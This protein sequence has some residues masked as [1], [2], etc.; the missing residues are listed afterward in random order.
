MTTRYSLF[1]NIL[2]VSLPDEDT[3]S[4]PRILNLLGAGEKLDFAG[5]QAYQQYAW[6]AFLVQVASL[7]AY[8]SG[9]SDLAVAESVW[10]SALLELSGKAGEAAWCLLNSDL[11]QPAFLQP[12]VPEGSLKTFKRVM[13]TPDA[14]DVLVAAKNHDVKQSRILRPK[15]DHWVYALVTLQTIEGFMG[16]GNYGIARMNGGFGSRPSLGFAAGL[17]WSQRF[18]R[19]VGTWL[20]ER[21]RLIDHYGYPQS[22]GAALLWLQP[23]DGQEQVPLR[24][25]DPFFIEVCRRVRLR[26]T[27][28]GLE[29]VFR[30]SKGTRVAVHKDHK[31]STGDIWS[32]VHKTTDAV[33]SVSRSGFSYRLLNRVLFKGD[34]KHNPALQIQDLGSDEPLLVAQVL[35]R[36]QG[37]TEGYHERVVPLTLR[38]KRFLALAEEREKLAERAQ[39][40]VD[41]AQT[42]EHRVLHPAICCLLQGGADDLDLRDQRTHPWLDRLDRAIDRV[43]FQDL[44]ESLES[45]QDPVRAWEERLVN[46][47]QRELKDAVAA[48]PTPLARSPRARARAEL[49][50]WGAAR[51]HLAQA[52]EKTGKKEDRE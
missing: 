13:E 15:P 49:R 4:L 32:P 17:D 14:L 50:F 51:K 46:L 30:P 23:W 26:E 28:Q 18:Q 9:F 27:G 43:F 41:R 3:V 39:D 44:W 35:A 48:C 11:A 20:Q 31:G 16:R 45:D 47:A 33:L 42:A 12:P 8:R 5:L 38:A 40:W 25:C 22:G 34:Y 36:G 37:V 24:T 7:A 29:A 1:D 10:R 19:D 52:F 2:R 21:S 6:H